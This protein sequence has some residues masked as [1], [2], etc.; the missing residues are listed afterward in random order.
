MKLGEIQRLGDSVKFEVTQGK[1]AA[2]HAE[3]HFKAAGTKILQ[4]RAHVAG[5]NDITWTGFLK[6]CGI[7]KSRAYELI[8]IAKGELTAADI[9]AANRVRDHKRRKASVAHGKQKPSLQHRDAQLFE[10]TSKGYAELS[11]AYQNQFLVAHQLTRTSGAL[12]AA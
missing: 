6:H 7:G 10:S 12:L 5:R 4:A 11:P 8:A 2:E 1:A 9:R 3:A